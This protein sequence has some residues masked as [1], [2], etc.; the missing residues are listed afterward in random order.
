MKI[1]IGSDE[2]T[3]PTDFVVEALRRRGHAVASSGPLK[4]EAMGWPD[5]GEIIGMEVSRGRADQ[6]IVFC[7]TRTGVTVAANKVSGARAALCFLGLS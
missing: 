3:V 5:L 2:K 4:G 6:G 7:W 1:S